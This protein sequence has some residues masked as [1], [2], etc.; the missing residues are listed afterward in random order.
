MLIGLKKQFRTKNILNRVLLNKLNHR[1]LI[2]LNY[3]VVVLYV[4]LQFALLVKM[5]RKTSKISWKKEKN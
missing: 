1:F 4:G 2:Y 5:V 3:T